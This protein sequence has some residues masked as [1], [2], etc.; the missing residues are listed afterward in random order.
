MKGM[1]DS[2][3]DL[4]EPLADRTLV[5]NLLRSLS[6]RY[7]HLKAL[8][9]RIVPFP[10]FQVVRN[11][12]LL[13]EL[14]MVTEAPAPAL[15]LYNA[16]PG[17][18]APSGGRPLTLCQPGLLPALLP[19][20]LRLLVRFPPPTEVVVPTRAAARVAAPSVV[21]PPTEVAARHG[22]HS[23]PVDHGHL[24]VAGPGPECLPSS[25]A[26]PP[27]STSLQRASSYASLRC[28]T[29]N[30]GTAPASAPMDHHLNALVPTGWRMG[31]RLP[32]CRLQHHGDDPT[33]PTRW[34]TSE[35]PTTPLPL[36]ACSLD[37]IPSIP[38]TPP[39]LSLEMVPLC[40]SPL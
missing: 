20:S 5:L 11:E 17:G 28:A 37:P 8:I 40:Q 4:G 21:V 12:L 10:T 3:R 25:G 34:K 7:D 14:T 15:A 31:P 38:P 24:H 1:V 32:H 35:L 6:P 13:E 2:L 27:D 18:Q 22:R 23:T 29:D 19:R 36:Q 9:K 26:G 33:P 39:R 16:P 30:S